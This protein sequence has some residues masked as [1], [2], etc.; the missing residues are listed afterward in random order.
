LQTAH[1]LGQWGLV[2]FGGEPTSR[3]TEDSSV[4]REAVLLS[5]ASVRG[6]KAQRYVDE[7]SWSYRA[8]ISSRN[9]LDQTMCR[10]SLSQRRLRKENL[11]CPQ[12]AIDV[13]KHG[14]CRYLSNGPE[15]P[16]CSYAQIEQRDAV[17]WG[18]SSL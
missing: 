15:V 13:D 5:S 11:L 9:A 4:G 1:F 14:Y 12:K 8:K 3:H 17:A 16:V 2:A 10:S 6:A 18:K 7:S